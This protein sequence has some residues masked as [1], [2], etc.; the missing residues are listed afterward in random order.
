MTQ[1]ENIITI[2][3]CTYIQCILNQTFYLLHLLVNF[4]GLYCTVQIVL[5]SEACL[6]ILIAVG[7]SFNSLFFEACVE[8]YILFSGQE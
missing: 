3:L 8:K 4:L 6:V 1:S 5:Y 2:I 7:S